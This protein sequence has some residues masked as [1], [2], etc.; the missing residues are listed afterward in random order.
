MAAPEEVQVKKC[1]LDSDHW[2]MILLQHR[3]KRLETILEKIDEIVQIGHHTYSENDVV[4]FVRLNMKLMEY[5]PILK[6][7]NRMD[8]FEKLL[9]Y[10]TGLRRT[11]PVW[12]KRTMYEEYRFLAPDYIIPTY[13][14]LYEFDPTDNPV[15][16]LDACY[17][18]RDHIDH[19]LFNHIPKAKLKSAEEIFGEY[20][21]VD[22][23]KRWMP[24]GTV[25]AEYIDFINEF[26]R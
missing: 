18:L 6:H 1:Y 21:M 15:Q 26:D 25:P 9:A 10:L 20:N 24:K 7:S 14:D 17:V 4:K 3:M 12:T 11:Y 22:F 16:F 8:Y 23:V 2:Y 5:Y 19:E 13:H